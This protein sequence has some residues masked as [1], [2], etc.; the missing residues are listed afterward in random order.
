MLK[1][2]DK[3]VFKYKKTTFSLLLAASTAAFS[4]YVVADEVKI[5]VILPL[6]GGLADAGND[7]R[8][9]MIWAQDEINKAGGIT[10]LDGKGLKVIFADTKGDAKEG[11]S[12]IRGLLSQKDIPIVGGAYQSGVTLA[13]ARVAESAK[14]PYLVVSALSD[15]ITESNLKYTFRGHAPVTDWVKTQFDFIDWLNLE[16]KE[17]LGRDISK[18][19]ILFNNSDYGTDI[20]RKQKARAEAKGYEVVGYFPYEDSTTNV[21]PVINQLCTS[22]PDVVL[23]SSF[24]PDALLI[25]RTQKQLGC[26]IP[27]TIGGGAGHSEYQFANSDYD[28]DNI[29]VTANWNNDITKSFNETINEGYKEKWGEL[30]NSLAAG[31]ISYMYII[32]EVLELAGSDN[33]EDIYTALQSFETKNTPPAI[34]GADEIKFN[35]HGQNIFPEIII[36]QINNGKY[37]TVYP[38]EI[39]PVKP[40]LPTLN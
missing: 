27:I 21:T 36:T 7:F 26:K 4:T 40:T 5:G 28:V 18:V 23:Q 37:N 19:A 6:T 39:S 32:K 11:I 3:V 13:T 1:T 30:P 33:K 8:Q 29:F 14:T 10:S 25:A 17:E 9:G 2:F 24:L 16:K 31:G 20:A 22:K 38:E 35:E 34:S 15:N 12:V